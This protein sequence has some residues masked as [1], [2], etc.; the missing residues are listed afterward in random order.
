MS[1][2]I[3]LRK[4]D[5]EKVKPR[6]GIWHQFHLETNPDLDSV[7][8]LEE[9]GII[10]DDRSKEFVKKVSSQYPKAASF[11]IELVKSSH[12]GYETPDTLDDFY[13]AVLGA[14]DLSK[15]PVHY[16]PALARGILA[17]VPKGKDAHIYLGIG[18]LEID[19]QGVVLSISYDRW[20]KKRLYAHELPH[21]SSNPNSRCYIYD[22]YWW[23][24]TSLASSGDV[25]NKIIQGP[26]AHHGHSTLSQ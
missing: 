8:G 18:D 5:L 20:S 3:T 6:I 24:F 25:A 15:F 21:T 11:D 26:W 23:A 17:S 1:K 16:V 2:I 4:E 14:G 19:G 22:N 7:A 9:A 10:L 13:K 12:F